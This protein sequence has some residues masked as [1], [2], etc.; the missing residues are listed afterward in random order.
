MLNK[1]DSSTDR[2]L[3]KDTLQFLFGKATLP[4]VY[5]AKFRATYD[6]IK[7]ASSDG[8]ITPA[9]AEERIQQALVDFQTDMDKQVVDDA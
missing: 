7:A 9:D 2:K 4:K 8:G 3:V 5:L 1:L 6:L